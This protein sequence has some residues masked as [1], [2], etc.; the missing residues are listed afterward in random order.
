MRPHRLVAVILGFFALHAV[1]ES[2]RAVS[3]PHTVDTLTADG[4]ELSFT[5]DGYFSTYR[6]V[7]TGREAVLEFHQISGAGTNPDLVQVTFELRFS[8]GFQVSG[9]G[10]LVIGILPDFGEPADHRFGQLFVLS[11]LTV[12][13][14]NRPR[15]GPWPRTGDE[16]VIGGEVTP[17]ARVEGAV[18]I[19]RPD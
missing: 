11:R 1:A 9:S 2:A 7:S 14:T 6:S 16:I 15:G 18:R 12:A 17:D 8:D 13:K 3:G 4:S 10:T 19:V 5:D